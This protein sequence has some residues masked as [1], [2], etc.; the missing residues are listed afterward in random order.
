MN[1]LFNI[2]VTIAFLILNRC[3]LNSIRMIVMMNLMI[4]NCGFHCYYCSLMMYD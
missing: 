4:P 1:T 3:C 2:K